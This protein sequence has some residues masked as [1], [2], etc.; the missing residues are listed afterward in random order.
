LPTD[1]DAHHLKLDKAIP[2][3]PPARDDGQDTDEEGEE[4]EGD[5]E[6]GAG[7]DFLAEFPDE[8]DVSL[9]LVILNSFLTLDFVCG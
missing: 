7:G 2:S 6:A 8:T 3:P 1:D 4:D 9:L 5:G